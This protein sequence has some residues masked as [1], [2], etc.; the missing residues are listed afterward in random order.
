MSHKSN[1]WRRIKCSLRTIWSSRN[2][3]EFFVVSGDGRYH[4]FVRNFGSNVTAE[5]A[6]KELRTGFATVE[7]SSAAPNEELVLLSQTIPLLE[8]A[9]VENALAGFGSYLGKAILSFSGYIDRTN[10][11]NLKRPKYVSFVGTEFTVTSLF[12]SQTFG[13]RRYQ[14]DHEFDF[15]QSVE[16]PLAAAI[17]KWRMD[18]APA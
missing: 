13:F 4:A 11:L 6:R 10:G 14:D 1:D 7:F 17:A 12:C 18:Y 2:Y 3:D 5:E 9:R 8:A 16:R 15:S